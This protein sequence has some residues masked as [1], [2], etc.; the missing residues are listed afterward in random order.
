MR[1]EP[2]LSIQA[3]SKS[4]ARRS[5]PVLDGVTL[6][7]R[8]GRS[9]GLVGPSGSGKSTLARCMALLEPPTRGEILFRGR[10]VWRM[11]ERERA[12]FRVGVQLVPQEPAASLNPRFTAEQA[13]IEPL[14][15]Q[16][17]GT[18][19]TRRKLVFELMELVGLP[20]ESAHAAALDSSGGQ[21]QRLALARALAL[22]PKLLI[23]DESL[24]GLDLSIQAQMAGLLLE[25][26]ERL[27]LSYVLI[28][29]DL[30]LV[31]R[32]SDDI[33]VLEH[34]KIVEQAS[35]FDLLANPRHPGTKDLVSASLAMH[36]S[37][38]LA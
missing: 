18:R 19:E 21:R 6:S 20:A 9:L 3:L 36:P 1:A 17:R 37:G 32:I 25:L 16:K 31:A 14:L 38:F 29:H 15:I 11:S 12:A 34:G 28:S 26:Q 30:S 5:G 4:Y 23:L 24:S 35:A 10:D 27:G 7:V 22:A 8:P 2:L 33:A 13:I